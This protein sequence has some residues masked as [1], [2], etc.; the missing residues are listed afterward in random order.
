MSLTAR[1]TPLHD[2]QDAPYA[3]VSITKRWYKQ[4]EADSQNRVDYIMEGAE[5]AIFE[6]VE[7]KLVQVGETLETDENC[8]LTFEGLNGTKTYY[9]FEPQ[10]PPET[11]RRREKPSPAA[12]KR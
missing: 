5:F 12:W 6:E 10:Q 11:A 7:G 9:V 3:K 1:A 2:L 4:W 8:A